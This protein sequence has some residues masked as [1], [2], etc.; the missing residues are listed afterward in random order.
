MVQQS[1][2]NLFEGTNKN[3]VLLKIEQERPIVH[4]APPKSKSAAEE[5]DEEQ[6]EDDVETPPT[7]KKHPYDRVAHLLPKVTDNIHKLQ[8]F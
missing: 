5:N 6:N 7:P 4:A 8:V 2:I 3:H 1:V